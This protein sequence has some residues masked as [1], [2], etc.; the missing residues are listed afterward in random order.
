MTH[1]A[2][3]HIVQWII[4]VNSVLVATLG[5]IRIV[6]IPLIVRP[7]GH[8]LREEINSLVDQA[9]TSVLATMLRHIGKVDQQ[10]ERLNRDIMKLGDKARQLERRIT[11]LEEK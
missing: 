10:M 1:H 8:K 11:T 6:F 4:Y 9:M 7:L 5:I 2:V 3:G